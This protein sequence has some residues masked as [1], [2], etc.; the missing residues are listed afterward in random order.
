MEQETQD[1]IYTM[2]R[3]KKTK[4]VALKALE[5]KVA[6]PQLCPGIRRRLRAL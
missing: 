4:G 2:G 1:Q 3:L 6:T 5:A